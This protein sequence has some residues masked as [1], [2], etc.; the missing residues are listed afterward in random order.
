MISPPAALEP[1]RSQRKEYSFSFAFER[2]ANEMLTALVNNQII[3]KKGTE[4]WMEK[5]PVKQ[6]KS[7]TGS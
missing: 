6:S 4:G 7:R 1:R 2:K 5:E 3:N